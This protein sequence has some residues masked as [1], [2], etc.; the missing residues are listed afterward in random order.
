MRDVRV[1][2]SWRGLGQSD[3]GLRQTQP[4]RSQVLA[5]SG[6][7]CPGWAWHTSALVSE[8]EREKETEKKRQGGGKET[9][10]GERKEQ[11]A[12]PGIRTGTNLGPGRPAAAG[13]YAFRCVGPGRTVWTGPG[14]LPD[15]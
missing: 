13:P 5:A 15:P 6:G 8:G 2:V 11:R 7:C 12:R 4:G 14:R 9:R 10:Q 1:S 3:S